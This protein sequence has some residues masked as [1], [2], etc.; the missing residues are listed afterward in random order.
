MTSSG[1]A[2]SLNAGES[3]QVGEDDRDLAPM[4]GQQLLAF[5]AGEQRRHLRRQKP[6]ELAALPVDGANQ[7]GG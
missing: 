2:D 1:S 7:L 5:R 4:A 6:G 3:P